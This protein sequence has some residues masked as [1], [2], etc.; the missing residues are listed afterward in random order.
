M[1]L[2]KVVIVALILSKKKFL[3]A[4]FYKIPHALSFTLYLLKKRRII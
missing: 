3:N 1:F 2:I 4:P